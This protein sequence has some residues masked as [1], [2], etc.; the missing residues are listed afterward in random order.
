MGH[1]R[2]CMSPRAVAPWGR[3]Q[4]EREGRSQLLCLE[5]PLAGGQNHAVSVIGNISF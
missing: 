1:N 2:D 4:G 3:H 5:E